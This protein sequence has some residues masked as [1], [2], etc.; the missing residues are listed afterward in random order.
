M[1][2][3]LFCNRFVGMP[4]FDVCSGSLNSAALAVPSACI[5]IV[6]KINFFIISPEYNI[7]TKKN[8]L[9]YLIKKLDKK[10][11]LSKLTVIK[12]IIITKNIRL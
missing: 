7:N 6:F 5:I 8:Q 11:K 9:C 3:C 12:N 4:P 1:G 10:P 2:E